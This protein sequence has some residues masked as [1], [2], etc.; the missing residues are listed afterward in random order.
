L[1]SDVPSTGSIYDAT[2]WE[3]SR[4]IFSQ[5]GN[6]S[7]EASATGSWNSRTSLQFS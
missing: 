5:D 7:N 2:A 4:T 3:I 6:T 1:Y